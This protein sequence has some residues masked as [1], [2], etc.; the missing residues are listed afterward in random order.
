M[1][2]P[3]DSPEFS[4]FTEAM[5]D[6]LSVSKEELEKRMRDEKQERGQTA[7]PSSSGRASCDRD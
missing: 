4:R 6:I 5:R 7:N 2:T 3:P 1:K